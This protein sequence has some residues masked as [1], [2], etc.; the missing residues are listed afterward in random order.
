MIILHDLVEVEAKDI[1][2]LD[3]AQSP[4]QASK[5]KKRKGKQCK[6]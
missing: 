3:V 2:A 1:S 5:K 6:T 4:N